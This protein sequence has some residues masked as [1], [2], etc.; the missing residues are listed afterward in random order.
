MPK[1]Y[2]LTDEYA[3]L[4]AQLEDCEAEEDKLGIIEQIDAVANDITI[5]AEAYAKIRMNL[6]AKA[7]EIQAQADIFKAEADRLS[8]IAKSYESNI[9]RLN[10]RMLFAMGIAGIR[11]I[12]TP[13]G[14]FYTQTT[15]SV[16]VTDAWAVPE[17]FTTPQEPKVDKAALKRA[18]KETGELLPGV[19]YEIKEGLRFR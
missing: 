11:Q 15:T 8:G 16:K 10:E 2:E 1:L 12:P 7:A 6:K 14:K 17:E 5:K 19:D 9:E 13:I 3:V 4:V 18:F